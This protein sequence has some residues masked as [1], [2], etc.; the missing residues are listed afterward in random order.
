MLLW[1]MECRLVEAKRVGGDL[2][3]ARHTTD[4]A[5]GGDKR[6]RTPR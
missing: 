6:S 2:T 1:V 3:G 5:G 4:Q